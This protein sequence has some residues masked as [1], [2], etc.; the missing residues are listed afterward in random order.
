MIIT[1]DGP[2]ASGKSTLAQLL[3][4]RLGF[5]YMNSGYLYRS[6]AYLLVREYG[7]NQT[8]LHNPDIEHIASILHQNNFE[9]RY[10]QGKASVFYQ[11]I[12]ITD[13]L[14]NSDVSHHASIVSAHPLVRA[15]IV[16]VQHYFSEQHDVITD[17]RD[18]GTQIYPAAEFK[19]YVT[20]LPEIRAQRLQLDYARKGIDMSFDDILTAVV[21]RDIRDSS[22]SLCPLKQAND[23]FLIDTSHRSVDEILDEITTII[24]SHQS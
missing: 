7:Y 22:R 24:S 2:C 11:G 12:D 4:T 13:F 21:A 23:A 19:F 20:A 1:L 14:K 6:V 9:Y 16:P 5:F 3:A 17:G 15:S 18:C 8:T 10:H